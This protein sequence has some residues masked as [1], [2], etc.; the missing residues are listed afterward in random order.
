MRGVG[1]GAGLPGLSAYGGFCGMEEKKRSR[2]YEEAAL[3]LLLPTR[4]GRSPGGGEKIPGGGLVLWASVGGALGGWVSSGLGL[5][6]EESALCGAEWS[7]LPPTRIRRASGCW[8]TPWG[9]VFV[10][11]G[12]R[13]DGSRA[14]GLDAQGI[15]GAP[16]VEV[17]AIAATMN[18]KVWRIGRENELELW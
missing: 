6:A 13:C 12:A 3:S 11:C 9:G 14:G 15:P 1:G 8:E 16:I 7:L 4:T 17:I 18:A 2:L 5:A 10:L